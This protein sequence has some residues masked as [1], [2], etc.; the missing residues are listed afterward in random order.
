MALS[1]L[2]LHTYFLF[3]FSIDRETVANEHAAQWKTKAQWID[4]LDEWINWHAT[5][6]KSPLVNQ[7]GCWQ[8][9]AYAR[10][11]MD[12]PAYQD[13]IFFHPFVR[14]VFFDIS[15]KSAAAGER[16]AL[17]RCYRIPLDGSR[18]VWYRAEDARGRKAAM[19][20]SDLRLFLFANGMGILSL[21]VESRDISAREA[22]WIN[23]QMRKIYPSS[24]RQLR[25]GRAPNRYALSL[26]EGGRETVLA[27]EKFESCSMIGFQPPL[28]KVISALLY[29]LDYEKR[30]FEQILDERM[31]V[32]SHAI[33]DPASVPADFARSEAC[34]HFLSGMLYVDHEW[35]RFRYD[36][37]FNREQMRAH[38]YTRWAHQGTYYGFTSYSNI[39]VTIGVADRGE[40]VIKEG[41][42]IHR[43]FDTRYYLMAIVALFYRATL[44]DFAQKTALVSRNLFHD[45]E[46]GDLSSANVQIARALRA[47]YLH[48]SNHWFFDELANKD[49]ETEHFEKQCRAYRVTSM[50][51]EVEQ[52]IEKMNASL[53]EYY[54]NRNTEAVNRLAM[55]SMILGAG[56]VIT[57]FF[58]MN[59]GREFHALFFEPAAQPH[60]VHYLAITFVSLFAFGAVAFGIYLV[61]SNPAAYRDI[62]LPAKSRRAAQAKW[63]SFKRRGK[64]Q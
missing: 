35:D 46:Q 26:E 17:I 31:I 43:M 14:R 8:R 7:L 62:L 54:Q 15:D 58:G 3:P 48:F 55:V 57:G 45:Q 20:V 11:D 28:S 12:S 51:T 25:E 61:W 24:G 41:D 5:A 21:G 59:F 42:L 30:E 40:H 9:A 4:G 47:E 29:F 2:H 50:R 16:E 56:A 60:W 6:G 52:E 36:P 32:Y 64:P 23:E 39:T 63:F 13:M 37:D 1:L 33:I 38:L 44:L 19:Q 53:N 27:E 22:L 49:E 10:A 34:Q 18:T